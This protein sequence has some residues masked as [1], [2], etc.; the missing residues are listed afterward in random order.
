M[1]SLVVKLS[2]SRS[3]VFKK[4]FKHCS[5]CREQTLQ[6]CCQLKIGLRQQQRSNYSSYPTQKKICFCCIR[7]YFCFLHFLENRGTM[8]CCG[9]Y[10]DMQRGAGLQA[11]LFSSVQMPPSPC[12]A[13]ILSSWSAL[14]GASFK[15]LQLFTLVGLLLQLL[16]HWPH[17]WREGEGS[18]RRTLP[19]PSPC[20]VSL[21]PGWSHLC[22]CSLW[23]WPPPGVCDTSAGT[24]G[25]APAAGR[26]GIGTLGVLKGSSAA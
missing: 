18:G 20:R 25:W 10:L 9:F 11:M 1:L 17:S 6:R 8:H 4:P 15:E 12:C 5:V 26:A 13:V 16:A 7:D 2:C 24:A 14:D 19:N 21:S 22:P 3:W 23:L